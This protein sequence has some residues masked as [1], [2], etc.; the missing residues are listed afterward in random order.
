[1]Q[2]LRARKLLAV[3]ALLAAAVTSFHMAHA[4]S[5]LVDVATRAGRTAFVD[6]VVVRCADAMQSL[7]LRCWYCTPTLGAASVV[8]SHTRTLD[9]LQGTH[10][11]MTQLHP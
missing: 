5:S 7:I 1:M 3:A 6:A 2:V 11:S 9:P 4:Q 8:P 10:L